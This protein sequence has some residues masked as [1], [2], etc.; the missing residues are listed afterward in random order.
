M[1]KYPVLITPSQMCGNQWLKTENTLNP[2]HSVKD[3]NVGVMA[4]CPNT[5]GCRVM[6]GRVT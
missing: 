4:R 6:S 2:E 1:L 5:F 3:G